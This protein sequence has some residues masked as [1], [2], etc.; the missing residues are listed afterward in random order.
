MPTSAKRIKSP[1]LVNPEEKVNW[2]DND[3]Y[4]TQ[5]WRKDAAM[6]INLNPLCV[7]CQAKGRTVPS[8]V[9]D[10][11]KEISQGGDVWDW[12]NRQALCSRCH[13]HKTQL[14]RK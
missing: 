4:H 12:E 5:A 1:W 2:S 7:I 11:I 10:H 13:N 9:S 14:N 3:F 6:H 8:K